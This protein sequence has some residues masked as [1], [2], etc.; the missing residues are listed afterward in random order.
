MK[1]ALSTN[2]V[3][4]NDAG[5]LVFAEN[6]VFSMKNN[7]HFPDPVPPLETI[8]ELVNQFSESLTDAATK[9]IVDIA[10]KNQL[11]K[12]LEHQLGRLALYVMYV[13]DESEAILV[14][15]GYNLTKKPVENKLETPQQ[16]TLRSG[17]SSGE[18]TGMIKAVKGAK[19][20]IFEITY[21]ALTSDSTWETHSCSRRKYT[22]TNLTP[23]QRYWV[24]IAVLGT[25]KQKAYSSPASMWAQ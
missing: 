9:N 19:Y 2:F 6:I 10:L 12:R 11:R 23:G 1:Q 14:S 16:P 17:I 5:F 22:F 4:Y 24:R 21:G 8:S 18:I 13:A 20:Y 7:P 3:P 15:S 25:G